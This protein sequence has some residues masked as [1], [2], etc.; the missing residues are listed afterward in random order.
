MSDRPMHQGDNF[1]KLRAIY[2]EDSTDPRMLVRR[3]IVLSLL[4]LA[5]SYA[6]EASAAD[7]SNC[8]HR[9]GGLVD[10]ESARMFTDASYGTAI[11]SGAIS[12][13]NAF[14]AFGSMFFI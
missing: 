9:V 13:G 11:A 7:C 1:Q 5:V 8:V 6:S 2:A 3:L 14:F 12:V 10:P 4:A